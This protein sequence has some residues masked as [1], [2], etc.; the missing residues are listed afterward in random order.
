MDIRE[1]ATFAHGLRPG[2]I[3]DL[4]CDACKNE[5]ALGVPPNIRRSSNG[6]SAT[7]DGILVA[8]ER[9][10]GD[11][12]ERLAALLADVADCLAAARLRAGELHPW[13][14][15]HGRLVVELCGELQRRAVDRGE[16]HPW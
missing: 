9:Y 11:P 10:G 8:A 5:D 13:R 16:V 3:R 2:Q 15:A 7:R 12:A 6:N 14:N 1:H 4:T